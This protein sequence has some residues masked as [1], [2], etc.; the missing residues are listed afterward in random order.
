MRW[1]A[2]LLLFPSICFAGIFIHLPVTEHYGGIPHQTEK[3]IGIG[4]QFET[5]G[6]WDPVIGAYRNSNFDLTTYGGYLHDS[7]WWGWGG[8]A[9]TGYKY[10]VIPAPFAFVDVWRFRVI[11]LPGVVNVTLKFQ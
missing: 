10:P 2:L 7:G 8:V 4:Y 9:L 3:T 1:F 11:V 6:Y 5:D